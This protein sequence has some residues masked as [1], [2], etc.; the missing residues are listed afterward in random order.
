MVLDGGSF[1]QCNLHGVKGIPKLS[2]TATFTECDV[3]PDFSRSSKISQAELLKKW[4]L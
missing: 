4:G 1:E 3:S 2:K